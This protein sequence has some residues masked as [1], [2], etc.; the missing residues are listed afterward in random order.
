MKT[1]V[2]KRSIT[3]GT[4]VEGS[5]YHVE[6][7]QHIPATEFN[8]PHDKDHR[9][10]WEND[11]GSYHRDNILVEF[12]TPVCTTW[13][14][15]KR[16]V[17]TCVK[18]LQ[19]EYTAMGCKVMYTP[20]TLFKDEKMLAIE[21]AQEMGCD[22]DYCAYTG[23]K[24]EGAVAKDMGPHR[25][26]SGHLHLGGLEDLNFE[27]QCL[28]VRW[29]DVLV[30]LPHAQIESDMGGTSEMRRKWY[31][32]AGRFRSKPYGIEYRTLSNQWVHS[33]CKGRRGT[34][35]A[36]DVGVCQ[37]IDMMDSGFL[38]EDYGIDSVQVAAA[39]NGRHVFLDGDHD[40]WYNFIYRVSHNIRDGVYRAAHDV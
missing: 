33:L 7:R 22:P 11:Q 26:A 23:E 3:F 6:K 20:V 25:A 24:M 37:A 8:T 5:L 19:A 28:L 30:G 17:L 2:N 14:G 34:L 38:P 27:Q 18:L 35:P 13:P 29:L 39:I 31:G 10:F 16:S 12:Q 4:D 1:K 9:K 15:L 36:L 32:Q 21:E 40:D